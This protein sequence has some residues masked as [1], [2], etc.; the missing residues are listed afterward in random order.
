[1][2]EKK[3]I[4]L[5]ESKNLYLKDKRIEMANNLINTSKNEKMKKEI[6]NY[7]SIIKKLKNPQQN[8]YNPVTN[9]IIYFSNV[10]LSKNINILNEN[11]SKKF[12]AGKPTS[13]I[14]KDALIK[15]NKLIKQQNFQRS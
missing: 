9:E 1:M 14:D 6:V 3:M 10:D 8:L 13:L 4:E 7:E 11:P 12:F 2:D 15:E 5:K